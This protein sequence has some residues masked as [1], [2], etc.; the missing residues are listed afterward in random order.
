MNNPQYYYMDAAGQQ[1]GPVSFDE[2]RQLASNGT[3]QQTTLVWAEGMPEWTAASGLDGLFAGGAAGGAPE[4]HYMDAAGQQIGP[5][6]FAELQRLASS[7]TIEPTTMVWSQGMGNWVAASTVGGLVFPAPPAP[8]APGAQPLGEADYSVTVPVRLMNGP[9]RPG[10]DQGAAS[11]RP[12]LVTGQAPM[13]AQPTAPV[14]G[15]PAAVAAPATVAPLGAAPQT[16]TTAPQG[17]EYPVPMVERAN[18]GLFAG[19][20]GG[21]IL[22]AFIGLLV[23]RSKET[24]MLGMGIWGLGLLVM[25]AGGILMFV[26]LYRAWAL[27]QPGGA[28][29]TPGKAVGFLFIPF[30]NLYW[31]FVALGKWPKDWNRIV[32]SYPNLSGAPK[33]NEMIFLLWAVCSI[34]FPPAALVL[35][36]IAMQQMCTSINFMHGLQLKQ[37][38]TGG[39]IRLY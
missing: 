12:A 36:F 37:Q 29:T 4:W 23:A 8:A 39:G 30:F 3:V 18:Y 31:V 19:L 27:L 26:Y 14:T 24:A 22:L 34:V 17:G 25:V 20:Y 6:S 16:Q 11:A 10:M 28:S 1:I 33:A 15:Q 5:V 2:L 13:T 32:S 21:G 38:G 9:A 7:G 35:M